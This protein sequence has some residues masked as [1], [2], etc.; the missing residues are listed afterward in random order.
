MSEIFLGLPRFLPEVRESPLDESRR[1]AQP[2]IDTVNMVFAGLA[3]FQAG[4]KAQ[5]GLDAWRERFTQHSTTRTSM[6]GYVSLENGTAQTKEQGLAEQ[7]GGHIKYVAERIRGLCASAPGRSIGVLCRTNDTIAR[8]IYELRELGIQASEEGG[9]PLTDSPAV[10]VL[11]SL[12]TLADHPG[13][14]IAWH[15]V[16]TSPL[17]ECLRPFTEPDQLARHLRREILAGGI[18]KITHAWAK[19]LVLACNQRDLSR[20]QQLIESAYHFQRRSTL[21]TDD[22]V[23]W[24][25]LQ[26]VPDPS[27][28]PVR[29]MTIHSA[30]GLQFDAVVLPE[31][32]SEL[33]G[34]RKPSFVVDRDPETLAVNFV[35]RYA[36]ETVQDLLTP[37]E[38]QAFELDRRQRVEESLS[39][40]Y[41]AMTRAIHALYMFV[42]GPRLKKQSDVWCN[43]LVQS[44]AP[45]AE[46]PG[47]KTLLFQCGEPAWHQHADKP[48]A[49]LAMATARTAPIVFQTASSERR[50]GL[51]H[52]APSKQEGGARVRTDRLFNPGEGTGTAAGT[53]Y[54]TWFEAIKWLDD[55][56][57]TDA[58]LRQAA[59]KVRWDLPADTWRDLERL[60]AEFQSWVRTPT[61]A[62]VLRRAAYADA[63][64]PGFPKRLKT[65][66]TP[67]MKPRQVER[68]RRF[69]VRQETTFWDGS[70]DR[71]VWLA[72]G[73]RVV[74]ADVIDFKTDMLL[75]GDELSLAARTAHYRPQLEAYRRAITA[76]CRLPAECIAARLVFPFAGQVVD[77]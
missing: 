15:H 43:L 42:P 32:D 28:A 67:T 12:F 23:R 4:D 59:A 20:L 38:R 10:E 63:Q 27:S 17:E 9:N 7:R 5:P 72:D 57:P 52:A 73:E 62:A 37:V 1:S 64:A 41:V 26:R 76:M 77:V 31:L 56:E 58:Q 22:F 51:E 34:R 66:W 53:L 29:V 3:S 44:L 33:V 50:R 55:G 18:G 19:E 45:A 2:I 48:S 61:I 16:K 24:V 49:A 11:L 54:H 36:N 39:L 69:V 68:E 30:K 70:L 6:P 60:L 13:H 46:S 25:R 21:R 14:S 47:E 74:A 8:M 40:L 71:V 65:L 75:P 35:C